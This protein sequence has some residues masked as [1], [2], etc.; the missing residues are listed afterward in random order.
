VGQ[1][2][3]ILTTTPNTVTSAVHDRMPVILDP[4]SY[5]LWL[6]PEMSNVSEIS[7]LLKPYDPR[8]MG[9]YAVSTRINHV[10]ND[11]EECSQPVVHRSAY[12]ASLTTLAFR[13]A[14]PIPAWSATL[15]S[16]DHERVCPSIAHSPALHLQLPPK[17][18][19]RVFCG[20]YPITNNG[21]GS[22]FI[23]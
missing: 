14:E 22:R 23:R 4:G 17:A 12:T 16:L 10:A 1:V 5:D 9:S 6:D 18:T 19:H 2:R 21:H 13:T 3:S 15:T 20:A 11:D 7:E 8:F